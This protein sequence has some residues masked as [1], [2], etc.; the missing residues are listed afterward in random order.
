MK[1]KSWLFLKTAD[2]NQEKIRLFGK[3]IYSSARMLMV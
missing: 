3:K 2:E 1:G